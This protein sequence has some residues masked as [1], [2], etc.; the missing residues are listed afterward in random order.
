MNRELKKI[1]ENSWNIVFLGG[2]GVSTESGIPDFRS[3]D[4]LYHQTYQFPPETIISHRFFMR[5]PEIFY[6]FYRD[7]MICLSARPN[8]AHLALAELE[9]QGRLKAIVTQNIDGLHQMAGSQCFGRLRSSF[10]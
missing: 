1:I 5:Y 6:D 3:E 2:A 10:C 8:A 9:K 4:G 7:R